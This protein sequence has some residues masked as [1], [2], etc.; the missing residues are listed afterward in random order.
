MAA[1]L[2]SSIALEISNIPFMGPIAG[3]H[4]GRIDGQFVLNP[5][6][7]QLN[8]SDIDLIVAN[9]KEKMQFQHG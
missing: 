2:G 1:M 6:T 7:E 9:T 5:S 4:V 3:A 8:V